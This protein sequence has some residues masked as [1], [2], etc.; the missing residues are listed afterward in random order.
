VGCLAVPGLEVRESFVTCAGTEQE[1]L[2]AR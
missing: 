1:N 2:S